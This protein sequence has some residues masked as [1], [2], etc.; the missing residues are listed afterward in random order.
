M[1]TERMW[2]RALL[3][4]NEAWTVIFL[5]ARF[6]RSL[7]VF[8]DKLFLLFSQTGWQV[9]VGLNIRIHFCSWNPVVMSSNTAKPNMTKVETAT[10]RTVLNP[11]IKKTLAILGREALNAK[12]KT[13]GN[14]NS[15]MTWFWGR[16]HHFILSNFVEGPFKIDKTFPA[17]PLRALLK[18]QIS[19]TN[20]NITP[21]QIRVEKDPKYEKSLQMLRKC[22]HFEYT[23][24]AFLRIF[25]PS[26]VPDGLNF[27]IQNLTRPNIGLTVSESHC[28]ALFSIFSL[29]LLLTI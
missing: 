1:S 26:W 29:V 19:Y 15:L 28:I 4:T 11:E 9:C 17:Q 5:D 12:G 25:K 13:L 16:L 8:W 24:C 3:E 21:F 23:F 10:A 22:N 7:S 27:Y 14:F 6:C 2:H 18:A 20:I